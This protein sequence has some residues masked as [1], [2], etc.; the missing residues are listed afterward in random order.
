LRLCP[1]P[2]KPIP[3]IIGGHAKPALARAARLGDGWFS[4]NSDPE[5]LKQMIDQLNA[6]RVEFGTQKHPD[7]RIHAFNQFA[8][9]ADDY[10]QLR[11]LGA[12]DLCAMGWN[13]FDDN[14]TL[15]AKIDGIRRFG[16]EVIAR[17]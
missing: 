4:A 5:T 7:F 8:Q 17:V 2:K 16:D 12:T 13:P 9:S 6:L 11:D 15:Q 14:L 1:V 3:V 10:K